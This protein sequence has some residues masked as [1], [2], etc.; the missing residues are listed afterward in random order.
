MNQT[1]CR[2]SLTN[3][4]GLQAIYL[5]QSSLAVATVIPDQMEISCNSHRHVVTIEPLLTLV[6]LQPSCIVLFAKIKLPRYFKKYSKGFAIGIKAANLHPDKFGY[7]DFHIWKSFNVSS[8]STIKKSSM[9]K[10]DST[11]SVPVNE[12]RGETE[13]LKM[14]N[15]DFKGKSWFYILVEVQD[16]MYYSW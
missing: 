16:L 9:K 14:L 13:S 10:L 5:D 15:F 4:T 11:P 2:M 7:M 6:N 12:L 8:L 3:V 1:N